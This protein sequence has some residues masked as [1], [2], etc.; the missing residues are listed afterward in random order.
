L[1]PI[2]SSTIVE[3]SVYV[4]LPPS[5]LFAF[6]FCSALVIVTSGFNQSSFCGEQLQ[7]APPAECHSQSAS[8]CH[9][10]YA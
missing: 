1:S 6:P 10:A 7:H 4:P 9:A 3:Y 5:L 2:C 8:A